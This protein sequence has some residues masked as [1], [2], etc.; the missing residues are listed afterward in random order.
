VEGAQPR[1]L[2]I[3]VALEA[4]QSASGAGGM[5]AADGRFQIEAAPLEVCHLDLR[6]PPEGYT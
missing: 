3:Y 5:S 4:G 6:F 2:D 1:K